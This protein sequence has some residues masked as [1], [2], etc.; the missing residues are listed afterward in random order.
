MADQTA[1]QKRRN[2]LFLNHLTR[3]PRI[4]WRDLIATLGPVL[5]L[6]IAA[7]LL[8]LHFVRPA[9]P[10]SL[11]IVSGPEGSTYRSMAEKYKAILE[12]N[13]ITLNILP[14]QGSLDNLHQLADLDSDADIGFVPSGLSTG[15]DISNLASLGSVFYQPVTIFYHAPNAIER[16]SELK[17]KSIAIGKEGSGTRFLALA[18]LKGN[19]IV[20]DTGPTKLE[21]LEG[22]AAMQALIAHK[23]DAIFLTGDSAAP[24]NIR[25]L[26]HT[27]GI[28]LY[29]FPQADAYVRRFRYLSKI[30][31]PAGSFDLGENLPAKPINVLAPTVELVARWDLHPALSDLL[32][33]AAR[34]VN[35]RA[36]LFQNAGEFPA[37]LQHDF[38]ISDDATR[39]YQSGKGFAYKHLPF[40]L[41]SLLD[42]A[43]VVLVPILV[44]LIPGLRL[45]PTLYGWRIKNRIYKYYGDLMALERASLEPVDAEQREALIG[46]LDEIEKAVIAV[47]MPGAFAD[48]IYILRQHISFVRAQLVPGSP[49]P[50]HF[51]PR[52]ASDAAN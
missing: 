6:S 32:I 33:E 51:V 52:V 17:G 46:K 12:R 50:Q 7:V 25:Q 47:K 19:G 22:T 11:N 28:R 2:R 14:S 40:W 10:T 43:L 48:Q 16:L 29:D 5:L 38:Q 30:E 18:L 23:V 49:A 9:P 3:I 20:T 24:A 1:E 36:G 42:R 8:A 13:G 4:S 31:L 39:Y 34:E 35:G 41:A 45:V 15:T 44:V 21:A 37:P 27:P 26:M